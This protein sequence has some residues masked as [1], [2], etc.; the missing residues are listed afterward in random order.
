[1]IELPADVDRLMGGA[2]STAD[3]TAA[4]LGASRFV[5]GPAVQPEA[6][7]VLADLDVTL[8][9]EGEQ[10]QRSS[11]SARGGPGPALMALVNQIVEQGRVIRRGQLLVLR[12]G[13]ASEAE[14]GRY[15]ARFGELG[16]IELTLR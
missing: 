12:V 13:A 5:T 11:T 6:V 4:N 10:I 3:R 9:R 15:V 14:P 1:V 2:V 7:P 16:V 8:L